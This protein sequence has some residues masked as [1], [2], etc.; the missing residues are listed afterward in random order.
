MSER[1]SLS[2]PERP[3]SLCGCLFR[4]AHHR[5]DPKLPGNLVHIASVDFMPVGECRFDHFFFRFFSGAGVMRLLLSAPGRA[6][7]SRYRWE[8]RVCQY[9]KTRSS[10]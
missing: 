5:R 9:G 7:D 6:L 4:F 2:K 3:G 8:S 1:S 10:G